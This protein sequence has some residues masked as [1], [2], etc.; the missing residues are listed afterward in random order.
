MHEIEYN[1]QRDN[2]NFNGTFPGWRQCFS[3]CS[4]MLM[5]F[6]SKEIIVSDDIGLSK[7][8]DDVEV[9]IGSK[10]IGE[11]IFKSEGAS[12]FWWTVQQAGI[13][14][15]LNDHGINGS[16]E[17]YDCTKGFFDLKNI[18]DHDPVII[19]TSKLGGLS[20]GH[21]I[22][23]TGYDSVSLI[24]N[25]PFGDANTNYGLH[26][27]HQVHYNFNFLMQH[28]IY[29]TPDKIRCMYFQREVTE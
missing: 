19:G 24:I 7:Y 11:K 27:G 21:I 12:S 8:L 4:W 5:S 2:K 25:D 28:C 3:T 9:S 29:K 26:N 18:L 10:G 13:T 6:Y 1:S 15:W 23:V 17:F 22:L 14:K 16:A 20:G